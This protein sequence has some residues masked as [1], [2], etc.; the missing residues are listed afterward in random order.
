MLPYFM[1][2]VLTNTALM[3]L[4]ATPLYALGQT[5]DKTAFKRDV[6]PFMNTYCLRCHDGKQQKGNF[7]IDTL[8]PDFANLATAQRW[9]EVIGRMNSGEMPPPKEPQPTS[10]ELG[11]VVDWLATR[12][13]EGEAA[14]MARRGP[15]AHY[16]LSREEYANTVYD[17]LGVHYDVTLPGAFNEDPR[18][19]GFERIGSML[20]LSPSHVDRY[21]K[22]AETILE[23][24]FP[25]QQPKAVKRRADAIEMHHRSDRKRIEEMG[26]ADKVRVALWP[27]Y[28]L[29]AFRGYFWGQVKEPGIYKARIQLSGLQP[30]NGR[31][32]HLSVW[33]PHL[34]RT[35]FDQDVIA[36]EDKPVIVEFE[37]FLTMPAELDF[38]NEVPGKF[39]EGHTRNVLV[40]GGGIFTNT[41]DTRLLNPTGYK[42]FDEDGTALY[43]LLLVDWVDWEGPLTTEAELKKRA[44]V[45]PET[46]GDMAQARE[47]LRRFATRAWRRPATDA[48]IDR[49]VKVIEKEVAAG[50]KFR[51]AYLAALTGILT[52]NNFYYLAEGSPGE[53]RERVN[54]WE[55]ASR[56][57]YFLWGSMP[58]DEL[59][60]AAQAGTLHTPA[61]LRAQLKRMMEDAKIK[62]FTEAFPR[63]WLQLHKVGMFTP[64]EKLYP[65]YDKWL[66]KSMV[67][68][69]TAFF[70]EVLAQNLSIRE[71]LASDWTMA[72]PRLASHYKLPPLTDAMM[73]RIGLR[74]EDHRGGL[75]TQASIL[76]L[77]S[78]GTRHRPVHRGVW[79]SEAIFGKTP[80]PPPPNVEPIEPTPAT[81]PKATVRMQLEAHTTNSNCSSCH[82][83]IDPLGFAFDN[84]DAVGRWRI[85]EVVPTGQGANPPINASGKLPD[86]RAFNGPDDFK[87]L[88]LAD[89]DR[90]APAFVNNLST[91]ALRRAMTVDD[92]AQINAIAQASKKDGYKMRSLIENLVL[93]EL[94]QKR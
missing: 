61:V 25:E 26:I 88:L 47:S 19:H 82:K 38:L 52:S 81:A 91:F 10:D 89:L 87:Q 21:F 1:N 94:F 41:K 83:N 55:L 70:N 30:R 86:G 77:T 12:I 4:L 49:Y 59:F 40:G 42:L 84:Y 20:S 92:E 66:E 27:G 57:S 58:D 54:D 13:K 32:P 48:E 69:T 11:K 7:R 79:V 75:L 3:A 35:I 33:H 22:A 31:P 74:P 29:S 14:R 68:E 64:D 5:A 18:W 23:R 51:E 93:S 85:E 15:V 63:Q 2:H 6:S 37:T 17:L 8:Q 24:A 62:R 60:Q 9:A 56:L 45:M 50:A 76:S 46:A 34:K 44:G 72:N 65:D 36:P 90:F 16:R 39:P 28:N 43:P 80:P 78:D 53:R 71:F 73:Q 67:L